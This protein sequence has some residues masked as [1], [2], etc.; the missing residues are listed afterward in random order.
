MRDA[1][2]PGDPCTFANVLEGGPQEMVPY[3]AVFP[4]K[5]QTRKCIGGSPQVIVSAQHPP[6]TVLFSRSLRPQG[7]P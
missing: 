5:A 3:V 7:T 4:R 6:D 2:R 1:I